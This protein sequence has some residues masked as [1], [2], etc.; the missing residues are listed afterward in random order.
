MTVAH[1]V[2]FV[3]GVLCDETVET[4]PTCYFVLQVVVSILS[5]MRHDGWAVIIQRRQPKAIKALDLAD[6]I[7]KS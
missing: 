6:P 7:T 1:R 5:T 3:I 4:S 2:K